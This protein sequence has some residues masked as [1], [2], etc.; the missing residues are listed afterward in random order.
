MSEVRPYRLQDHF[1]SILGACEPDVYHA[2]STEYA[3]LLQ[4]VRIKI[5]ENHANELSGIL[6]NPKARDI[7]MPIIVSY[8]TDYV[9][10]TADASLNI[11]RTADKIYQDMAGFSILTPYLNDPY[12]E[13]I[14][15]NAWNA[16]EII[17]SDRFLLL[18]DTFASPQ[19]CV[20]IIRKM[21]RIGGVHIDYSQPVIDSYIGNGTRITAT[22]PPVVLET[23]GA[24]ASIRKQTFKNVT[25]EKYLEMGFATKEILDFINTCMN[26][27]I[28]MGFAGSP[29]AGKTTFMTCLLR[30][31]SRNSNNM[32]S[33]I[34]TIEEAREID[35]T[36]TE[37]TP[38]NAETH[39][40]PRMIRRVIHFNT[41]S[42]E[43]PITARDLH[44]QALR[45]NPKI[46]VPAEMRGAEAIEV[47]EAGLSGIQIVTSF[48]A[49]GAQD[50]YL[51]VLSMCQMA[52]VSMSETTLLQ[53]IM[54]AFPIMVFL[55]KDDDGVRR[56]AEVFEPTHISEGQVKGNTIFRF[57]RD[58]TKEDENGRVIEVI[59]EFEQRDS[60]SRRLYH[61][62]IQN[63]AK[64]DALEN[65]YRPDEAY[66][67]PGEE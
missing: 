37:D 17:W 62:L 60:I 43:K 11:N 33:R 1:N 40:V 29:G 39:N 2:T 22:L 67:A 21:V 50:G 52:N 5:S 25:Q 66:I 28:S 6:T 7:L 4:T 26:A 64:K 15:I 42:G 44:K 3:E 38:P 48:H 36:E 20:D 34:V 59:G 13:E 14:N 41:V 35:L 51:R 53:M 63:G 32:N 54:K 46:L 16:I 55:R 58:S 57:R 19:D 12:V 30:D 45:L 56:I 18:E 9:N 49:W 31:Y 27:N 23:T 10:D 24:I 47:V 8:V 61:M 65:V